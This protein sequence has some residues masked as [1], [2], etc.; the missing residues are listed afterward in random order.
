MLDLECPHEVRHVAKEE[1]E[2]EEECRI[3]YSLFGYNMNLPQSTSKF[4]WANNAAEN[5]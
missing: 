1:I 5:S 3:E 2:A 4:Y